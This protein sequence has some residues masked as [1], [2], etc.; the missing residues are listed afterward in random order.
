[1]QAGIRAQSLKGLSSELVFPSRRLCK[2]DEGNILS[3]VMNISQVC[4]ATCC[5]DGAVEENDVQGHLR[6]ALRLGG[7][8]LLREVPN[9]LHLQILQPWFHVDDKRPRRSGSFIPA[10]AGGKGGGKLITACCPGPG[11]RPHVHRVQRFGRSKYSPCPRVQLR[12]ELLIREP[13][14]PL[15]F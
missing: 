9:Y 8:A 10:A 13:L 2:E 14:I 7:D 3:K 6:G 1:M 4:G 12:S 5:I 11:L 15:K